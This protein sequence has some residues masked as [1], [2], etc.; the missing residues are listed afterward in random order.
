MTLR[1]ATMEDFTVV[2]EMFREIVASMEQQGLN[3]WNEVYPLSYLEEDIRQGQLYLVSD[4]QHIVAAFALFSIHEWGH[5]IEWKSSPEES[6]YLSRV[7]VRVECMGQGI[8]SKSLSL[9]KQEA[10]RKGAQV[11]RLFVAECN[12]SAIR[13]YERNGFIQAEGIYEEFIKP[14]FSLREYG[15]ETRLC[16]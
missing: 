1:L 10:L 4:A 11:L 12:A 14:G 2:Y 6:M 3:V 9:A 13:L 16:P 8:G 15:Y 7:G 5:C